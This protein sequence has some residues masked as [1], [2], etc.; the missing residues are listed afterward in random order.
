MRALA[1]ISTA[2]RRRMV[3]V[4]L[5]LVAVL[6]LAATT[7]STR[8]YATLSSAIRRTP[9]APGPNTRRHQCQ[10]HTSALSGVRDRQRAKPSEC[11]ARH[12]NSAPASAPGSS[13]S[14]A[15]KQPA[16]SAA[17]REVKSGGGKSGRVTGRLDVLLELGTKGRVGHGGDRGQVIRGHGADLHGRAHGHHSSSPVHPASPALA[18]ASFAHA[19]WQTHGGHEW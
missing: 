2:L 4:P 16:G 7:I 18:W 8:D 3:W 19:V 6:A 10:A 1:G 5:T 15:T 17:K 12:G 13:R 9:R 14:T 11:S